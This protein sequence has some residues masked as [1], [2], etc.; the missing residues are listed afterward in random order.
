MGMVI[1][2]VIVCAVSSAPILIGLGYLVVYYME[3]KQERAD[4]AKEVH[5]D[6]ND[7]IVSGEDEK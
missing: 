5:S 6:N 3:R 4:R 1:P 7:K 2:E